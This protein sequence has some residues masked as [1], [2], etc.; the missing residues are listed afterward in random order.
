[1]K[2]IVYLS[3][4]AGYF[5]FLGACDSSEYDLENQIP[6]QYNKI[7]YLQTTGKQNL[8]LYDTGENNTFSYAIIKS[9]SEPTLTA[10]ADVKVLTQEELDERFSQL[11]GVNYKLLSKDAYSFENARLEFASQDR[12]RNV[13]VSVDPVKVKADMDAEPT[14]IW[15]LPLYVTSDVDSI[16]A[17]RN[18]LFLQF[19]EILK[20]SLLFSNTNVGTITKQYGLVETFTQ[21]A[22][23]KLDVENTAWDITCSFTVD[24][25]YVDTY[26]AKHKTT[27]K[28]LDANY[29]FAEQITLAKGKTE[30]PL[31]VTIEGA[32]LEPGDYM[33]PIKMSDTSLFLPKEGGDVYP[34]TIR[35]MGAQL[36]RTGWTV[37]ASS[38]TVEGNGNGAASNVIDD[39]INTYWHSK[40]DGYYPPLPHEL[41][42]DTQGTHKFTQVALQ[43]RLG[44]NYA[45]FGY[46]YVSDTGESDSW[47]EVGTFTMENQDAVQT[48][49]TTPTEGRYV[50]IKVTESNNQ[51]ACA[52]FSEIF[53]YGIN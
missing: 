42:I 4:L 37:T 19:T 41:I 43:R 48:F 21:E 20:P 24:A 6:K 44:Y 12:Y 5:V 18:S 13:T 34:L 40:W 23:F 31:V 15:V 27:Y 33:L 26:N 28:L 22:L 53:L 1:M 3:M 17:N 45:R 7:L 25:G 38:Q 47:Q 11:E 51:S 32:G 35:I 36:S 9:G 46:F 2:K 50:K 16:N 39:N 29:S 14:A 8:T 52:A 10:T 49:S 30:T